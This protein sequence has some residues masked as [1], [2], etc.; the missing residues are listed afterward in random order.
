MSD[1]RHGH[2]A[3]VLT[4]SANAP[5]Y[6]AGAKTAVD[7]GAKPLIGLLALLLMF[8]GARTLGALPKGSVPS[9]ADIF[10][11]LVDQFESGALGSA[12]FSTVQAWVGGVLVAAVV[13]IP[14]GIAVGLSSWADS[15]TQRIVEFL[16]PVPVVALVPI[17]I[18]LFG[19][20]LKMQVFLI[21]IACIWP[22]LLGTRGGVR[23]VDP[24]QVDTARTFGLSRLAVVA[25]VVLPATVPSIAT[26]LRVG[27]SL[28]IIVAVAAEL[29]SG[30]PGLGQLMITSQRA[31]DNDVFWACLVVAGLFGVAANTLLV[32]LERRVASW[33]ELSTEARR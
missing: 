9:T 7:R 8:E 14:L 33:Q 5:R 26:A 20:E 15:A 17:A 4:D 3:V 11:A 19:I 10:G 13:G 2:K 18:V 30:S 25:R 27:A 23:A 1:I 22:V 6:R 28:G 24:L 29:I 16:R 32:Y 12:L 31:G 21:A